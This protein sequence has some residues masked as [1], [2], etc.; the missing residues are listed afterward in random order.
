VLRDG[1]V[2]RR[3]SVVF[4]FSELAARADIEGQHQVLRCQECLFWETRNRLVGLN[5]KCEDD[6]PAFMRETR[7]ASVTTEST[8]SKTAWQRGMMSTTPVPPNP[9]AFQDA[10]SIAAFHDVHA[11]AETSATAVPAACARLEAC[12]LLMST[13][14]K[15]GPVTKRA[16][17]SCCPDD[18][19]MRIFWPR[20]GRWVGG[21]HA[22]DLLHANSHSLTPPHHGLTGAWWVR[23]SLPRERLRRVSRRTADRR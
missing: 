15:D 22:L 3:I 11:A 23:A 2:A 12:S 19:W 9:R 7:L 16:G 1:A 17:M 10:V 14:T 6:G 4:R 5:I 20:S 13:V 21:L 18:W 8:S